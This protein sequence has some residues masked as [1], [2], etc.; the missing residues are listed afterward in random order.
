MGASIS[1]GKPSITLYTSK[2]RAGEEHDRRQVDPGGLL[3]ILA[4]T[5]SSR[6]SERSISKYKVESNRKKCFKSNSGLHRCTKR[7]THTLPTYTCIH[8]TYT[9]RDINFIW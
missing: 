6:F 5:G 4:K 3:T 2:P 1:T 9:A 7:Y 8:H